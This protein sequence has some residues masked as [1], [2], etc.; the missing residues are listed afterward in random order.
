MIKHVG[1]HNN[2]K[3]I[4]L[5]R[6]VPSEEHMCLVVYS[7]QLPS[8]IHDDI[9]KV[10]ESPVGQQAENFADAL[11]RNVGTDGNNLL[12]T[13]HR[14]RFIKKVQANQVIMVPNA[15][16]SVRLDELNEIIDKL[17]DGGKAAEKLAELDAQSGLRDP[18]KALKPAE[19]L[20]DATLAQ[21][22]LTQATSMMEEAKKLQ[23]EAYSLSPALKPTTVKSTTSKKPVS[24]TAK[25][26]TTKAS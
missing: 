1:K 20:D 10:L 9:A 11:D 19:V 4:V 14:E 26:T 13:L 22:L 5:F 21:N 3:V 25:K 6:K 24:R 12:H 15:K 23:E 7:E 17:A 2:K 18:A 8:R 16:S